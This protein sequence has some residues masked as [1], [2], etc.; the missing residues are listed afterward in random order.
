MLIPFHLSFSY[1]LISRI[2]SNKSFHSLLLLSL[3]F[4]Q[5]KDAPSLRLVTLH[6]TGAEMDVLFLTEPSR[7]PA[8]LQPSSRQHNWKEKTSYV[9]PTLLFSLSPLYKSFPEVLSHKWGPLTLTNMWIW[10][11]SSH[12]LRLHTTLRVRFHFLK[13]SVAMR[14]CNSGKLENSKIVHLFYITV[15]FGWLD[16]V[17]YHSHLSHLGLESPLC[18]VYPCFVPVHHYSLSCYFHS[19]IHCGYTPVFHASITFIYSI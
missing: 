19:Q 9:S 4:S 7:C 14:D 6:Y 3:Q 10:K 1:S 2:F 12:T 5:K 11:Q 16:E 17:L 13:M 18:P 8:F 15:Y